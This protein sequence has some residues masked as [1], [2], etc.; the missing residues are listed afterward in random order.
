MRSTLLVKIVRHLNTFSP[1]ASTIWFV[2]GSCYYEFVFETTLSV[3]KIRLRSNSNFGAVFKTIMNYDVIFNFSNPIHPIQR[4]FMMQY[5]LTNHGTPEV[6]FIYACQSN[7]CSST[8]KSC[9]PSYS[10]LSLYRVLP[11][12]LPPFS[13]FPLTNV[14]RKKGGGTTMWR[15]GPLC[16]LEIFIYCSLVLC[17]YY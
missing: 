2:L 1:C 11:A 14:G 7:L 17:P 8:A 5:S 13:Q 16:L 9:I 4:T 3:F 12:S 6:F 15:E 10:C